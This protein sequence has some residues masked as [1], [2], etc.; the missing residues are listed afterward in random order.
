MKTHQREPEA[1]ML[2]EYDFRN[3]KGVRG[4]YHR[5]YQQGHTVP[6]VQADGSITTQYFTLED[7]AVMLAPDVRE[8]F[9]DSESVNRALRGLIDLIPRPLSRRKQQ[10]D[11]AQMGKGGIR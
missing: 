4:K 9:P 11:I 6:I 3:R 2:P 5:A 10:G 8:Y 1:S 7:G